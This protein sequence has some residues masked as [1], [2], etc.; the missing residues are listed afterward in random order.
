MKIRPVEGELFHSDRRLL[1]ALHNF[2][3]E[4]KNTVF[5]TIFLK[6]WN[7]PVKRKVVFP[8]FKALPNSCAK[9]A[10]AIC[11]FSSFLMQVQSPKSLMTAYL[12]KEIDGVGSCI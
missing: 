1:V 12:N 11:I 4:P 6:N 5:Y 7:A 3:N 2:M 10:V 9:Y 8:K